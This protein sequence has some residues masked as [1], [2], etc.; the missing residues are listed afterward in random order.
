MN[1]KLF[2]FLLCFIFNMHGMRHSDSII[3]TKAFTLK[4][5]LIRTIALE[6][7]KYS[8]DVL[9]ILPAELRSPIMTLRDAI[10]PKMYLC[11]TRFFLGYDRE[12]MF[13]ALKY[14]DV[15]EFEKLLDAI[16][17]IDIF[18]RQA[19]TF[20]KPNHLRAVIQFC[21]EHK[22]SL[23]QEYLMQIL[24]YHALL[25]ANPADCAMAKL[26]LDAGAINSEEINASY[27]NDLQQFLQN[28]RSRAAKL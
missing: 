3:P 7:M 5:Q 17:D 22:I 23:A 4:G 9:S 27:S 12:R 16:G 15:P 1:F 28:N 24:K 21:N 2:L 18:M 13:H 6:D 19:V 14:A 8:D 26:L 25:F 11:N 10:V 20:K